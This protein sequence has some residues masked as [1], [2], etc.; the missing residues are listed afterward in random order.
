MPSL[1]KKCPHFSLKS[2]FWCSLCSM[3]QCT[4]RPT[5]LVIPGCRVLRGSAFARHSFYQG[6]ITFG[7]SHRR[8]SAD[9]D[10]ARWAQI[11]VRLTASIQTFRRSHLQFTDLTPKHASTVSKSTPPVSPHPQTSASSLQRAGRRRKKNER[12]LKER[13][14]TRDE[15]VESPLCCVG[16]FMKAG[17]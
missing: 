8:A 10:H 1:P 13:E 11:S 2:I 9:R 4:N 12:H 6:L 16:G 5:R 15:Y 7:H 17:R 14:A 3:C